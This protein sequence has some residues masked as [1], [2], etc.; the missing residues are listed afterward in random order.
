MECVYVEKTDKFV[1]T[2]G[3]VVG[4]RRDINGALLFTGALQLAKM[5]IHEANRAS[6]VGRSLVVDFGVCEA[7]VLVLVF[8]K[9]LAHAL[10]HESLSPVAAYV[11]D[12]K[13]QLTAGIAAAYAA[14]RPVHEGGAGCSIAEQSATFTLSELQ[15]KAVVLSLSATPSLEKHCGGGEGYSAIFRFMDRLFPMMGTTHG[16]AKTKLASELSRLASFKAWP[17][18]GFR[19]AQPPALARAGFYH[20]PGDAALD[21][22]RVL[23]YSCNVSLVCWEPADEPWKEHRRHQPK[24]LFLTGQ[25]PENIPIEYSLA[26]G[27]A[28][29]AQS[30]FVTAHSRD[31]NLLLTASAA[32]EF[33]VFDT[34]GD[35][36][37]I[38]H[39]C[40]YEKGMFVGVTGFAI[41]RYTSPSNRFSVGPG[42]KLFVVSAIK[43]GEWLVVEKCRTQRSFV[44]VD[45]GS[46]IR[47]GQLNLNHKSSLAIDLLSLFIRVFPRDGI[48]SV[49]IYADKVLHDDDGA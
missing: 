16:N 8:T 7:Q 18:E 37:P 10:S 38:F 24:C 2:D 44:G 47:A 5:H 30:V 26:I 35:A 17:H 42:D 3:H 39:M 40:L 14:Q 23:C 43:G 15:I 6:S 4:A 9:L 19:Y 31:S 13:E 12:I 20:D 49:P 46:G 29:R 21:N 11:D 36:K 1:L 27:T 34:T 41:E 32:G 48:L 22:D 28:R 25:C 45:S 33:F